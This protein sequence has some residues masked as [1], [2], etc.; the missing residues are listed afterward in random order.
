MTDKMAEQMADSPGNPERKGDRPT[1]DAGMGAAPSTP[2]TASPGTAGGAR[3]GSA[4]GRGAGAATA[5]GAGGID[6]SQ[7][8]DRAYEDKSLAELLDAPVSALQGLSDTDAEKLR[9]AFNIKTVRD[10]A[11]NKFFL[12]AR[13]LYLLSGER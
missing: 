1:D 10:L 3:A 4:G 7:V 8:F 11:T 6:V 12:R 5:P 13:G 2:S 9:G